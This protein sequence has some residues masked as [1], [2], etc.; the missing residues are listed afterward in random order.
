MLPLSRLPHW[1]PEPL[2]VYRRNSLD[3]TLNA[4]YDFLRNF[5]GEM[6]EIFTDPSL[7]QS[8]TL[9]SHPAT[10]FAVI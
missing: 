8:T 7:L 3:P 2:C 10:H 1:S 5:L 9:S 6:A 4:T